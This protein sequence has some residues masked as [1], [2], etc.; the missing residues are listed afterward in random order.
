MSFADGSSRSLLCWRLLRAP[1]GVRLRPPL[2][3]SGLPALLPM[4]P[5]R[6]AHSR[7]TE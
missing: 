7:K 4:T 1:K 2:Q 6:L 5:P 3:G